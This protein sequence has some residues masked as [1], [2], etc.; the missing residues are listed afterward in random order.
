MS[1]DPAVGARDNRETADFP[2]EGR[3]PRGGAA[4][5]AWLIETH[6]RRE[7]FRGSPRRGRPAAFPVPD[8]IPVNRPQAAQEADRGGSWNRTRFRT[9]RA[10]IPGRVVGSEQISVRK[11]PKLGQDMAAPFGLPAKDGRPG[12]F[13][14]PLPRG[15]GPDRLI[16]ASFL[17]PDT[18]AGKPGV[19]KP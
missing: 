19:M 7:G 10:Y 16:T 2:T 8:P 18:P 15:P 14:R 13:L 9:G 11:G 17:N 3:W 4:A 1:G 5:W 12:V 6:G